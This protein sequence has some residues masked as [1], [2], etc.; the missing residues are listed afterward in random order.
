M[1]QHGMRNV[2]LTLAGAAVL[3]AC[4]DEQPVEV[5]MPPEGDAVRGRQVF[6]DFNCH[7]C[8]T[9]PDV[10]LPAVNVPASTVLALGVRAHR[11]RRYGDLITAVIYPDHVVSPKYLAAMKAAGR[12][13]EVVAM[14]RFT[15]RMTVAQLIDLVEFLHAQYSRLL[16]QHYQG[17]GSP[18]PSGVH[19]W[20]R[21]WPADSEQDGGENDQ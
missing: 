6:I 2:A 12:E 3:A 13:D 17:K 8:H 21:D 20:Y 14:P 15:D 1:A 5:F 10:E 7:T 4:V 16:S 18:P 11:V 9:I 19:R